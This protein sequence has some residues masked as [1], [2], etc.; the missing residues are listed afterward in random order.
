MA[1]LENCFATNVT[2]K[3]QKTEDQEEVDLVAD[4]EAETTVE[5]D[6]NFELQKNSRLAGVFVLH[7]FYKK[8]S[9]ILENVGMLYTDLFNVVCRFIF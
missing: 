5:A 8:H 6:T 9:N 3:E 1:L 7:M 4:S 2:K